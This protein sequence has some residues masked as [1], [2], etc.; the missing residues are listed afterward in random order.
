LDPVTALQC[1]GDGVR[2]GLPVGTKV[3][4]EVGMFAGGAG[5]M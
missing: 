2:V 5:G 4:S 1:G 3:G